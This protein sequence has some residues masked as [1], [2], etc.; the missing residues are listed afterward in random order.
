MNDL[1]NSILYADDIITISS[2]TSNAGAG[3]VY[4]G[5]ACDY[6]VGL[7]DVVLNPH[8]KTMGLSGSEYHNWILSKRVG[9]DIGKDILNKCLPISTNQAK[10]ISLID[11]VFADVSYRDNLYNFIKNKHNDDFIL[12]KQKYLKLNKEKIELSKEQELS[13]MYEEFWNKNS[14][15]H[16]LRFD[17][18]YKTKML[19]TPSRLRI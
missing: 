14:S 3:G 11:C 18:V 9:K 17:F 15:F 19:K 1:I 12:N 6:A 2:F 4:I 13:I 7:E 16:K 5:L 10:N 8:Y